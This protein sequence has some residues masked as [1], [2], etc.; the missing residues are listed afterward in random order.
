ME[1][2]INEIKVSATLFYYIFSS[3]LL[4]VCVPFAIFK[5]AK[6]FIIEFIDFQKHIKAAKHGGQHAEHITHFT[7]FEPDVTHSGKPHFRDL[8]DIRDFSNYANPASS[9]YQNEDK[10]VV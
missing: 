1:Q 7:H 8:S 2:L 6:F 5:V 9:L 3:L 10:N 4:V